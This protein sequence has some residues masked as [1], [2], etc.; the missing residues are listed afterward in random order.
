MAILQFSKCNT[1]EF[2]YNELGYNE[3]SVITYEFSNFIW[4]MYKVNG[5][6]GYNELGYNENLAI[7]NTF[8]NEICK[9]IMYKSSVITN[10]LHFSKLNIQ[11]KENEPRYL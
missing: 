2:G 6:L 11:S 7:T 8:L 5:S 10:N 1:V 3:N 4:F 9:F